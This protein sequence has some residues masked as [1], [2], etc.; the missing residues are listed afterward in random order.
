MERPLSTAGAPEDRAYFQQPVT[1]CVNCKHFDVDPEP[2]LTVHL[3]DHS[4]VVKDPP[5]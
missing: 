4:P 1:T 5:H 2:L 3:Q